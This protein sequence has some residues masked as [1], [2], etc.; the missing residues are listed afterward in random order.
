MHSLLRTL[1]PQDLTELVQRH[2]AALML[3]RR[4]R[5]FRLYGHARKVKRWE[6]VR[7]HLQSVGA[8]RQ[9]APYAS[10][11]REWRAE[12]E[13][14][15]RVNAIDAWVIGN[16]ARTHLWGTHCAALSTHKDDR[17]HVQLSIVRGDHDGL[18]AQI[19]FRPV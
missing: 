12:P 15:L 18:Q 16:E 11:R 10:V 2:L 9:L 1:L 5:W 17:R 4:W 8:W 7:L 3:Q 19:T 14:W 6:R 13:S